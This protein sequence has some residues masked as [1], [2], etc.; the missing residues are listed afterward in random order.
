MTLAVILPD[1]SWREARFADVR[2]C[3]PP[4]MVKIQET[5][6]RSPDFWKLLIEAYLDGKKWVRA[7]TKLSIMQV[8][9]GFRADLPID[10][11]AEL[12]RLKLGH[13]PKTGVVFAGQELYLGITPELISAIVNGK[14]LLYELQQM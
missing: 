12:A 8:A 10:F 14:V 5:N 7:L 6:N 13:V 4:N 9:R 2:E 1:D 11:C 3:L